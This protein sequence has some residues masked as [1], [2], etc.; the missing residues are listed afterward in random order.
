MN[1]GLCTCA[2]DK[3]I[4]QKLSYDIIFNHLVYLYGNN[5]DTNTYWRHYSL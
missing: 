5:I 2:W 4:F 1:K 3:H